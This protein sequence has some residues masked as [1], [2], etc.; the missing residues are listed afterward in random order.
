MLVAWWNGEVIARSEICR[1]VEG[2]W[3]FPPDSLRKQYFKS[4]ETR[5]KCSWKGT[6]HYYNVVV[7]RSENLDGAWYYPQ[8][9]PN[10]SHIEGWGAFWKG[11]EVRDEQR[12]G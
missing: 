10:A 7:S 6:A 8:P 9:K 4:S 11:I 1:M 3:Y 5:T 12:N 2:N